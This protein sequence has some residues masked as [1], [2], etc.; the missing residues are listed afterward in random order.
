MRQILDR[1]CGK[2]VHHGKH[3]NYRSPITGRTFAYGYHDGRE[4]RGAIVR[5]ILVVDVGLTVE[6]ARQEAR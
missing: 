6:Q 1:I 5:R 2:P 3:P 4:I